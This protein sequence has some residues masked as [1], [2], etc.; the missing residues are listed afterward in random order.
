MIYGTIRMGLDWVTPLAPYGEPWRTAR[1][2]LHSHLHQG[3]VSKYQPIQIASARKLA[4]DILV[5]K[6]EIGAVSPIVRSNFGRMIMKLAY[7]IE[8][9][10]T[11]REQLSMAEDILE[12]I[13][14]AFTPGRFLV[15]MFTFCELFLLASGT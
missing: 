11:A 2:L 10:K 1:R 6:Q 15:D 5:A 14:E 4:Q 12:K 8:S 13:S 7:G 3:V 9:E